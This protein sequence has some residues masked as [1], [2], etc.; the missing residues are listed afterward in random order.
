MEI[1]LQRRRRRFGWAWLLILIAP[2]AYLAYWSRGHRTSSGGEVVDADSTA[3]FVIPSDT[4]RGPDRL[5]ELGDFLARADTARDERRQREFVANAFALL[6]NA[7]SSMRG[8]DARVV[9]SGV[10]SMRRYAENLRA[11]RGRQSARSD[12]LIV[13]LLEAAATIDTLRAVA[14]ASLP[15]DDVL[16]RSARAVQPGRPIEAQRD[17][18]HAFF[19]RANHALQA[20]RSGRE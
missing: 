13:H 4:V 19:D 12:S 6:A 18:V 14:Y 3:S 5:A 10:T 17:T 2:F 20:M 1:R 16:R 8:A 11:P 7:V 9:D 15:D